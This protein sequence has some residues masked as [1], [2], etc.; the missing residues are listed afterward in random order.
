MYDNIGGKIKGLAV[1][2]CI[3][4]AI[5]SII[6]GF[7]MMIDSVY[8]ILPGLLLMV[9]GP[10]VAWVSSWLL[11]AFGELAE[12][13][14]ENEENT[15]KILNLLQD[16][17]KGNNQ[18]PNKG[19]SPVPNMAKNYFA[20]KVSAPTPG[21]HSWRCSNCGS[22]ISQKPCPY[23]GEG[24]PA[25]ET[26][27]AEKPAPAEKQKPVEVPEGS[28]A[29]PACNF[30]QPKNRKVCWQCGGALETDLEN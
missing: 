11:Y 29:C 14:C 21:A 26:A 8:M 6:A 18:T 23:C 25:E 9:V 4:E 28:V 22:M 3:L 19:N 5:A 12:K 7:G 20:P 10:V 15:R 17:N 30:V 16:S 1:A 2:M 13:T 27:P 24:A